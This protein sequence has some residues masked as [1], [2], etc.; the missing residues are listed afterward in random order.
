LYGDFEH[1]SHFEVFRREKQNVQVFT[2]KKKD[3][4]RVLASFNLC[5]KIK[6]VLNQKVNQSVIEESPVCFVGSLLTNGTLLSTS[7]VIFAH[8]Q[9][10]NRQHSIFGRHATNELQF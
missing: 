7:K 3:G 10:V 4:L 2:A 9:P 8:W 1:G 5:P 6:K